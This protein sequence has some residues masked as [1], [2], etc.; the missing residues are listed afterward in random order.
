MVL[1]KKLTNLF[2]YLEKLNYR[3]EKKHSFVGKIQIVTSKKATLFL[4]QEAP[5]YRL[6][7]DYQSGP[8]SFEY[9]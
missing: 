7:G 3:T 4:T 8:L 5:N 1:L 2:E 6:S 9:F